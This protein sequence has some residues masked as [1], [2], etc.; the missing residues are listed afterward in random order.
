MKDGGLAGE[1][2]NLPVILDV[3]DLQEFLR[4]SKRGLYR[5]LHDPDLHAY[6]DEDGEWNILREDLAAWLEKNQLR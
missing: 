5:V 6:K 2:E 1:M 3:T 4:I